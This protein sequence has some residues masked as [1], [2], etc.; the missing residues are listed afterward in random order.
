MERMWNSVLYNGDW[1]SPHPGCRLK[2]MGGW[3]T[4][5]PFR[6]VQKKNQNL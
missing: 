5:H 1:K 3:K 6:G 4:P 2:E